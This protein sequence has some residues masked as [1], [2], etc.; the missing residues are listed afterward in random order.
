M[1][2]AG[3]GAAH[4]GV[5]LLDAMDQAVGQQEIQSRA[6]G[7]SPLVRRTLVLVDGHRSGAELQVF[8]VGKGEIQSVLAELLDKGCIEAVA[9]S[10]KAPAAVA[11]AA[12]PAALQPAAAPEAEAGAR[13][14]RQNPFPRATAEGPARGWS[15]RSSAEGNAV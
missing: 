13:E 5:Q 3:M 12:S 1:G 2:M 9:R 14:D 11:A 10:S 4:I 15:R 7:L 6:M 8:L